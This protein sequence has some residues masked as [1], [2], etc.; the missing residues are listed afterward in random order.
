MTTEE[1]AERLHMRPMPEDTVCDIHDWPDAGLPAR[2]VT[3]MRER[4]GKGGVN[5]C[6]ECLTRAKRLAG[7]ALCSS[8]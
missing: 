8:R 1:A 5:V 7:E 6:R 4:H 2:L 3:A